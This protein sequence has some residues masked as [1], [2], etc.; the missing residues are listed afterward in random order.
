MEVAIR[1]TIA[2]NASL[3]RRGC[4]GEELSDDEQVVFTQLVRAI[5]IDRFMKHLIGQTTAGYASED[6]F[7]KI[8]A[9]N[10]HRF[11]G[12]AESVR[13]FEANSWTPEIEAT[14]NE[15]KQ[16]QPNPIAD[17]STCGI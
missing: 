9:S 5:Y 13:S 17:P 16:D 10:M 8:V 4:I 7:I 6:L 3:W 15:L 1:A 11:P 12:F 2:D 14:L